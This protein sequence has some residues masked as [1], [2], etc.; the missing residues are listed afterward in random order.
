[1]NRVSDDDAANAA[2]PA[3]ADAS[4]TYEVASRVVVGDSPTL[5]VRILTLEPGQCVPWHWHNNITDTFFC[6]EGPM[7]VETRAPRATHVLGPGETCAVGPKVAHYVTG[8]DG[9]PCRFLI[10]QGV[11]EYDYVPVGG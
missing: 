8:V 10:V 2:G 9:G 3:M 1:M 6:M 7:Q 5:R 11:G 4:H